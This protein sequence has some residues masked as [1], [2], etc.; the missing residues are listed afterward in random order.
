MKG[1]KVKMAKGYLE[2][3]DMMEKILNVV[4]IAVPEGHWKAA[5]AQILRH[6]NN[7]IRRLTEEED[8]R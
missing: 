8:G 1:H 2:K 5:R 3:M 4:Q 6:T 7:T